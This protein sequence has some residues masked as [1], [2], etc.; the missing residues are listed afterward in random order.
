MTAEQ[1]WALKWDFQCFATKGGK[2]AKRYFHSSLP[3]SLFS[4]SCVLFKAL[5][6]QAQ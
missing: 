3:L 5:G 2:S 1:L 6:L 4:R